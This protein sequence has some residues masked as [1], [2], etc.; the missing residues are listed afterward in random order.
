MRR[1]GGLRRLGV[2]ALVVVTTV[3]GGAVGAGGPG[4]SWGIGDAS[5]QSAG[6]DATAAG[7]QAG[8]DAALAAA[9]RGPGWDPDTARPA[10]APRGADGPAQPNIL[11]AMAH[12]V[13][14]PDANP[15]GANDWT[16]RP[17]AEHP[18][19]VVLVHGT[20]L[21]AYV[22]NAGLA[23]ALKDAGYCVFALTYGAEADPLIA[24]ADGVN[25]VADVRVSSRQLG[26]FVDKVLAATGARQVDLVGHSQGGLVGRHYVTLGG[27]AD[28]ANPV[29][30]KVRTLVSMAGSYHGT[31]LGGIATL[32]RQMQQWGLRSMDT[33]RMLAGTAAQQQVVG[34]DLLAELDAHG[35]TV[36]GV[37]YVAMVTRYDEVVNPFQSQ[38][39]QAGP[40]A[41][42]DNIT[43]QD[44]CEQDLTEHGSIT[45]NRR[46]IHLM[47]QAWG[48]PQAAGPAPCDAGLIVAQLP[49]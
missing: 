3:A 46:A 36:P 9:G 25:G 4:G 8:V 24:L 20:F 30:N 28:R 49:R 18:T 23:P 32:G 15:P 1:A 37:H 35:D 45:Y 7:S 31:T 27:G 5:A 17:S 40:G 6:S 21:N 2:A 12:S 10:G 48:D 42:V 44:G 47:R 34:S 29:A 43:I 19:P 38:F 16:C 26:E 33:T 11:S 13:V 22:S 41:R 14:H 39:I